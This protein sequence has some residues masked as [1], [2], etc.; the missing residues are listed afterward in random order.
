MK[1]LIAHKIETKYLEQIQSVSPQIE[2]IVAQD[3]AEA[4][5]KAADCDAIYAR[6]RLP[7]PI[8]LAAKKAKWVQIGG[9]G[10]DATLYDEM[11]KSPVILTN[12]SGAFDIPIAEHVFSMILAFTRGLNV[13]LRH[14]LQKEWRGTNLLQLA[15]STI[16]IVGLG[17]IGGAVAKR[18][19]GFE[20]RIIGVDPML[21][22]SE[23]PDYV[24]KLVRPDKS[25]LHE[26]LSE[27]DLVA[28][29]C[30]LTKQ[31]YHMFG[32][33]EFSRLKPTAYVINIARGKIIDEPA[34]IKALKEK[35]IAGAG[36]DVFEQE[37]LPKE[38]ELWDLPNVIV[39][40]HSAGGSPQTTQRG[41]DILCENLKRFVSGQPLINVVNKEL[42]F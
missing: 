8:F 40:T 37:P 36:L 29:C 16:V 28:I 3:E 5:N 12:A 22:E 20:M 32:E 17:S 23:K 7:K 4:V 33:A 25:Q 24:E 30:P 27:A 19:Y 39:T 35:K 41:V 2:M 38:S 15:G 11:V 26:A 13:F 34:L 1:L 42:G 10:V 18:A 14:Q 9:A 31:T 21:P 6:G